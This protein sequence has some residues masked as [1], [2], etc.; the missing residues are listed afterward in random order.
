MCSD[1]SHCAVVGGDAKCALCRTRASGAGN[2][3]DWAAGAAVTA[4][5]PASP[6]A[7]A[8]VIA[9]PANRLAMRL[10]M[11]LPRRMRSAPLGTADTGGFSVN[12]HGGDCCA[13]ARV[14]RQIQP[15]W[16][17]G[18]AAL[19]MR[20]VLPAVGVRIHRITDI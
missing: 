15:A 17:C 14:S 9:E 1:A 6:R 20:P 11:K 13:L 5:A 16:I 3:R 18:S 19:E 7:E 10:C 8:A 2:G 4:V 12:H